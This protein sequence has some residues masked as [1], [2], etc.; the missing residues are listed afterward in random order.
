MVVCQSFL[1]QFWLPGLHVLRAV[2]WVLSSSESCWRASE[3]SSVF[4][5]ACVGGLTKVWEFLQ[6]Y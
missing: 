6:V 3:R 2:P 4:S 1:A 5:K